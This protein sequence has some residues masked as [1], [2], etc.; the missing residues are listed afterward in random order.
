[1]R[2]TLAL[3]LAV[4]FFALPND[5]SARQ[6]APA[7]LSPE[8]INAA[9]FSNGTASRPLLI[10]MQVLLDRARFSPGLI[11]G[12][13]GENVEHAIAA[14]QKER[15]LDPT[16]VLNQETWDRLKET[17]NE[18]IVV[19]YAL[20]EED[21]DTPLLDKLPTKMEKQADLK[22]LSYTSI[23]EAVA[24]KFHMSEALLRALNP[25]ASF[26]EPGESLAVL[27][28]AKAPLPKV[29][30]V[31]VLKAGK[32]LRALDEAG[33]VVAVFPATI[34]GGDKPTPSG[35]LKVAKV[36]RN[37]TYVYNPDYAFKSVK[38]KTTF[39]IQPGPNNPVGTVWIDL[40]GDGY[41]IHGTPDPDKI[42]KTVSHGCVRLT[43]WD[44]EA[45]ASAV[46]KGTMVAFVD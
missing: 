38:A 31:E 5:G 14:F 25:K 33:R 19:D 17:S 7:K 11:D 1:M 37:P 2:A 32:Q 23:R 45:L 46:R 6:K 8:A 16:G 43:N 44:A 24:E 12:E 9:E 22:R 27:G 36:A 26:E 10:K 13:D 28:V 3:L 42:G 15:G 39:K 34:G 29:D 30:K 35:V 40:G 20:T 18:P 4:G 21:A 41:G